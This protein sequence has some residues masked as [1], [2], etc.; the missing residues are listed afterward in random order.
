MHS[1]LSF[2]HVQPAPPS[3]LPQTSLVCLRRR[4]TLAHQ[5]TASV[6]KSYIPQA[7]SATNSYITSCSNL[8]PHMG[9]PDQESF[10][11]DVRK[12]IS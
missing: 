8:K 7:Q 12:N 4:R 10:A 11:F 6:L 1:V 2:R 3:T 9:Q 5:Q